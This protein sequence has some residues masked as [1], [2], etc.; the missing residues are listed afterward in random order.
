LNGTRDQLGAFAKFV[1]PTVANGR[2]YVS[3]FS[4]TVE[5]YGLLSGATTPGNPVIT[6]VVNGASY[7]AGGVSPGELVTIFGA[8][9]GPT[10]GAQGTLVGN[11]V[12]D[13]I[14]STQVLFGGV[15]SPLLYASSSQINAVVPFGVTGTTTEVQITSQ[16]QPTVSTT[17]PVQP[18][19]PALFSLQSNGGGSGAILNQDGSIN[20]RSNPAARG[21]VVVLYGTGGGLTTPTSVDGLLTSKPYPAPIL[22]F[23]VF[24]DTQ[25]AKVLYAGAAPGIVAGAL[26]INVVVPSNASV[27]PFDQVDVTIGGYQSPTTVSVAVK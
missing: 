21:S 9:L 10:V 4:R 22:P 14:D 5:V 1:P 16:G 2:V 20:S 19:S 25:P 6:S 7:L 26:Q 15:A 18:A 12:A 3:T 23:S 27:A 17:V 8:N 24:I 13:T 11:Q